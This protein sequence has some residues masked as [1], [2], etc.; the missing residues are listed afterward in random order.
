MSSESVA[1]EAVERDQRWREFNASAATIPWRELERY[2]AAGLV[3][4]LSEGQDLIEVACDLAEDKAGPI[5]S[6]IDQGEL[7]APTAEQAQSWHDENRSLWALVVA[8]WV[9]VQARGQ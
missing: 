7:E 1:P 9:L 4:T 8:P 2:Y 5:Q 6:L 3:R